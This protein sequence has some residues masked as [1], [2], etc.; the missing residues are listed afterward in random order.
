MFFASITAV[1]QNDSDS[2]SDSDN[3]KKK[4]SNNNNNNNSFLSGYLNTSIDNS[5]NSS[6][7]SD[8][9]KYSDRRAKEAA[10]MSGL[11]TAVGIALHNF[12]EGI[13]VYLASLKEV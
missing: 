1:L 10:L 13:A 4:T 5:N 11:L 9:N 7:D 3:D 2:D 12:P 8:N 6:S